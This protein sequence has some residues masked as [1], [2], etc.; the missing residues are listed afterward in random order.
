MDNY[1]YKYD[2]HMGPLYG[3]KRNIEEDEL[4]ISENILPHIYNVNERID[5]TNIN[6]YSIDPDGCEDC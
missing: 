1:N 4:L 6:T 2:L 5:M 3:I